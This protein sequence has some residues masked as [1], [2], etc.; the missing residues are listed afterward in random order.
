[1]KRFWCE[2]GDLVDAQSLP[3]DP[4]DCRILM[5]ADIGPADADG[6]DTFTFEVCTPRGLAT[7]LDRDGRPFWARATLVVQTFSWEAVEAALY[8]Y[9]HSVEGDTWA[10]VAERLNRFMAWEFEDYRPY[11]GN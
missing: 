6:G 11:G 1:V 8:Q 5:Y 3:P 7:R 10:E 2:D 4:E 9:V